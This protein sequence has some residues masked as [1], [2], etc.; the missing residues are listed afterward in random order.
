MQKAMRSSFLAPLRAD[1]ATTVSD[2]ILRMVAD[3]DM[4]PAPIHTQRMSAYSV[5]AF[6][7]ETLFLVKTPPTTTKLGSGLPSSH[8]GHL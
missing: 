8:V 1:R 6:L 7:A 4:S 3:D 2:I 5:S